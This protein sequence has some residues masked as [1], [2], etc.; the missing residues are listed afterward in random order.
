MFGKAEFIYIFRELY[1]SH[2]KLPRILEQMN[3]IHVYHI[4]WHIMNTQLTLAFIVV[5]GV[6]N[7]SAG[8]FLT[9]IFRITGQIKEQERMVMLSSLPGPQSRRYCPRITTVVALG[10]MM[11][12]NVARGRAVCLGIRKSEFQAWL[13]NQTALQS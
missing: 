8:W 12:T 4:T 11:A 1:Y 9:S 13:S 6:A 3:L 7:S 2:F 5:V 10:R